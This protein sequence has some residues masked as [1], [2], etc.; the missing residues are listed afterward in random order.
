LSERSFKD[1]AGDE[2][3]DSFDFTG[4]IL[5]VTNLNFDGMS[6]TNSRLAPHFQ[7]LISRSFYIDL[8]LLSAREMM[9]RIEDV[10]A[11]SDILSSMG[12]KPDTCQYILL[13]MRENTSKLRELSLRMAIKLGHIAGAAKDER[14]FIAMART[15]CMVR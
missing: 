10:I 12:L 5:F 2:I 14:D 7:A 3:P 11:N 4:C 13:F 1:E 15:T 8:N 9:I 6:K